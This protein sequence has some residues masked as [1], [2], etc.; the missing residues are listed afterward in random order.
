MATMKQGSMKSKVVSGFE[1]IFE[2]VE[3]VVDAVSLRLWELTR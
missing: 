2:N 3:G 1:S